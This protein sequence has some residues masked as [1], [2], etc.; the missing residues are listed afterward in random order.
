MEELELTGDDIQ[1]L[2]ER[3]KE[4]DRYSILWVFIMLCLY[5]GF[6]H[7]NFLEGIPSVASVLDGFIILEIVFLGVFSYALIK[8]FERN[9]NWK[10]NLYK[11]KKITGSF[12]VI[13]KIITNE[14]DSDSTSHNVVRIFS[15]IEKKDKY[16]FMDNDNFRKLKVDDF[17]YLEYF[18]DSDLIKTL[19]FNNRKLEYIRYQIYNNAW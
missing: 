9:L 13:E 12:K 5:Y 3:I 8:G 15:E 14:H 2:K 18:T 7:L 11:Q 16:I 19:E 4:Y 1:F 10:K 17:I 6:Y